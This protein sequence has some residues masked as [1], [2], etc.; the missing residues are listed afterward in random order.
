MEK[1][2]LNNLWV[3]SKKQQHILVASV[4]EMC[5]PNKP[6]IV[7]IDSVGVQFGWDYREYIGVDL[8]YNE[9]E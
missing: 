4:W 7:S 8:E 9:G 5:S 1:S 3:T 6:S 2:R